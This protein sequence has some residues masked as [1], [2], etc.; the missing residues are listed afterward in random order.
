MPATI[1]D[2]NSPIR[3]TLGPGQALRRAPGAALSFMWLRA[4]SRWRY[5]RN[6]PPSALSICAA[7]SRRE[8]C[9]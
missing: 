4:V 7:G 1:P 6:G 2:V 8:T 9:W 5:R 3:Y